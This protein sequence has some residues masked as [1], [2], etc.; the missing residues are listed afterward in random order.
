[1]EL[2]GVVRPAAFLRVAVYLGQLG[3]QGTGVVPF[4]ASSAADGVEQVAT[5]SLAE[6]DGWLRLSARGFHFS[7]PTI[8][9]K[10]TSQASEKTIL[11]KKGKKTKTVTGL[12]PKC[13]KGWRLVRP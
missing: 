4:L 9:V 12:K 5:T 11:C 6:K 13:P 8:T 10:L 1:M 2:G 3:E 7:Q